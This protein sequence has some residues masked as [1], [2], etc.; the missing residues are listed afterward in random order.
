MPKRYFI[1]TATSITNFA[2][3]L[4]VCLCMYMSSY[5]TAHSLTHVNRPAK[6]RIFFL[7]LYIYLI[8]GIER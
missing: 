4:A 6:D 5:V 7:V 8:K 3:C 1:A 2:N